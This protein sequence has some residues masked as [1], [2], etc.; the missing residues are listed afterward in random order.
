MK[1]FFPIIS[2]VVLFL[3]SGCASNHEKSLYNKKPAFYSYII[4]SIKDNRIDT[5]YNADVYTSSASCQKTIFALLAYK[6]LGSDYRY[7]TKLYITK[8]NHKI[9]DIVISFAG[10]P[11]LKSEDLIQ[12]IKPIS[13]TKITGK[14]FLDNSLFKTP[15]HSTNLMIDDLGAEY[16]QPV[17]S[18][19]LD[20][21]LFTITAKASKIPGNKASLSNDSGYA[22]NS[23]VTTTL[24]PSSIKLSMHNNRILAHGNI[25]INDNQLELKRSPIDFDHY[26]LYKIK[27][28]IKRSGIKGKI[29]IIQ[30]QSQL[31]KKLLLQ[32]ISKSTPLGS[33]IPVAIKKSDN[34]VFDC[35]YLK[36]INS[37]HN[38]P[39][40]H[41]SEGDKI[42]QSLI[43]KHF[44]IDTTKSMFVD[45]SGLSRYNRV[46]PRKLFEILKKGY[47]SNEFINS[48]PSPGEPNSTLAKRTNL[49]KHIRAKTGNMS[50]ISCLCG[51]KTSNHPKAFVII[52][53]S[54]APPNKEMLPILDN[55]IN[56]KLG[57]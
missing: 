30:D 10:D 2:I 32:N 56:N 9:H 7:E 48:L 26:V 15:S 52:T 34:L 17:S 22:M 49:S 14:I 3:I 55:F 11:T 57:K 42:I 16:A 37:Q 8:K 20:D 53:N 31:P 1:K 35:L 46:Q 25:N 40:T 4:G 29:E 27:T 24:E 44:N 13:N 45:G 39:I 50:G 38:K 54:F 47:H 6:I 28:I 5:E 12:L 36:I 33:I 23:Y 41:W 18:I 51:Y 19:T 43:Y 21:N